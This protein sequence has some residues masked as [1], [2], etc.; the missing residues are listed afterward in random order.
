MN[1]K[2]EFYDNENGKHSVRIIEPEYQ[3]NKSHIFNVGIAQKYGVNEAIIIENIIHWVEHNRANKKNFHDGYYWTYNSI[4]A[5]NEILPYLTERQIS[6]AL[7]KLEDKK[8]IKIGNYNKI[9]YDHTKWYTII[10]ES[11]YTNCQIEDNE[12]SN[13]INTS[14][15]PIPL[16]NTINKPINKEEDPIVITNKKETKTIS[17]FDTNEIIKTYPTRCIV[18][19]RSLRRSS[20]KK[21]K[22]SALIEKFGKDIIIETIE[23][24]I[25]DCKKTK[26]FMSN[27]STFINNFPSK[28]D[29]ETKNET[30]YI[31]EPIPFN[32]YEPLPE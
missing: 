19:D 9:A 31:T 28:D 7:K 29:F 12:M 1:E 14:V 25:N 24:Y 2:K 10:D 15:K 6:Y 13:Q 4:S 22:L 8:V 18:S 11:I 21:D 5:F 20:Y 32:N 26:T 23:L 17:D 27:F 3:F 16:I 30:E